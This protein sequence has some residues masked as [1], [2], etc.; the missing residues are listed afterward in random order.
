MRQ[1]T[2]GP[3]FLSFAIAL[4][5]AGS[6]AAQPGATAPGGAPPPP[7]APPPGGPVVAPPPPAP[8]PGPA[9]APAPP[10]ATYPPPGTYPPPQSTYPAPGY[11]QQ[12]PI[13]Q[14]QPAGPNHDGVMI[15]IDVGLGLTNGSCDGC[16][17]STEE[18]LSGPNLTI[19]SFINPATA[20]ALRLSGT[21]FWQD[22]GD[23]SVRISN[24]F[25]GGVVQRWIS[26]QFFV[27]GGLG[28]GLYSISVPGDSE[29]FTG[30][31][32]TGRLGWEVSQGTDSG[33][34]I[35]LELTPSFYEENDVS[36]RITSIG[37]QI[38]WMHY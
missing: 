2:S 11:P 26:P 8:A 5:L 36:V 12:P 35:A 31:A 7:P 28:L 38:G 1:A 13:Y 20:I 18:G 29:S 10:P 30:F 25:V 15:G 24:I 19:G 33:F 37:L 6:A 16:D 9:P 4:G 17:S 32:V 3:G 34:H 23:D 27:G 22:F 14:P 21:T